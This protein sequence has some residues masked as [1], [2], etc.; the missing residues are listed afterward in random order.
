M[1]VEAPPRAQWIPTA[2]FE[3]SRIANVVLFLGDMGV[4]LGASP[5]LLCFSPTGVRP[6]P[7]RGG[8]RWPIPPQFDRIGGLK[9]DLPQRGGSTRQ[10][11]LGRI[12]KFCDEME[13][14]VTGTRFSRLGRAASG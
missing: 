1:D 13:D 6:Q 4:Q 3:L 2:P 14:L 12:H 10:G 7:D 9:D 11:V 8:Y 5:S